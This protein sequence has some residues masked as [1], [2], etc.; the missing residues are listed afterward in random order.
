MIR[1]KESKLSQ[2]YVFGFFGVGLFS[3]STLLCLSTGGSLR[4]PRE[5]GQSKRIHIPRGLHS[6]QR[7]FFFCCEI[8]NRRLQALF[9]GRAHR[10]DSPVNER[11]DTS[12]F[13]FAIEL[14]S[15]RPCHFRQHPRTK[16]E[17]FDL[18]KMRRFAQRNP[19]TNV[20]RL[21]RRWRRRWKKRATNLILLAGRT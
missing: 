8:M 21:Q 5:C 18:K 20:G 9:V 2:Y 13:I 10:C 17:R 7:P 11:R 3:N 16:T 6:S 14:N 19:K 12:H 15:R 1:L 4:R